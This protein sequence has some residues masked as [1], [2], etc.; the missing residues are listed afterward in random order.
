[1]VRPGVMCKLSDQ[2]HFSSAMLT[3]NAV[4][5]VSKRFT[6]DTDRMIEQVPRIT[7]EPQRSLAE[8]K[9]SNA[10]KSPI[11]IAQAS[12]ARS[13]P[14]AGGRSAG[15]TPADQVEFANKP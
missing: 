11:S 14:S 12:G 15:W 2:L 6:I 5:I 3:S 13:G 8:T 9:W 4:Y 7:R 10:H 1:V